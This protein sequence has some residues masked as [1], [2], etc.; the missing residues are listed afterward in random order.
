[1]IMECN[2]TRQAVGVNE[3]V[4]DSM[5]EVPLEADIMLPDYCPDIVKILKCSL[6][7]CVKSTHTQGRQL[8]LEGVCSVHILYLGEDGSGTSSGGELR[9]RSIDYK[10]PYTKKLDLK[11]E[12]DQALV[13]L[14]KD[15]CYCNCRAVSKRRMELRASLSYKICAVSCMQMQAVTDAVD[16]TENPMGI[17]LRKKTLEQNSFVTQS[18]DIM[19]VNEE[20]EL[21][22]GKPS[23]RN[24]ISSRVC[25]VMNDCK[26]ISGKIITKGQLNIQILYTPN[27]SENGRN[28]VEQMEY[29]L[30][31][32]GVIDAPGADDSC[33]CLAG[34]SVC[35]YELSPIAD[36]DGENTLFQLR[37]QVVM[38]AQV[39]RKTQVCLADDCYS[40]R[41]A[42]EGKTQ[43]ASFLSMLDAVEQRS[44]YKGEIELPDG[45]ENI[46]SGWGSVEGTSIRQEESDETQEKTMVVAVKLNL[47][48]LALDQEGA[49]QFYDKTEDM[50]IK[51]PL[52][53]LQEQM[54]LIF[55]PQVSVQSF[56]YNRN[57]EN[58]QVRCEVMVHGCLAG[59]K[60]CCVMGDIEVD[61]TKPVEREDDCSLTIYYA[62]AGENLWEIAKRY[63][64]AMQSVM[65]SN[66]QVELGE[67]GTIPKREMLLIP[68]LSH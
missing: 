15:S 18:R 60:R 29:S 17:Q 54:K 67:S 39:C 41:Y 21:A 66:S 4:F 25:A 12:A 52:H 23:V 30:P 35:E 19:E 37:A 43:A 7:S 27:Q 56:D 13:F 20:L 68:I 14:M 55:F 45:I 61:Q 32:S 2:A 8:C 28:N 9:M 46:I 38:S 44:M 63:H 65:E 36:Q 1:M 31:I 11:Q 58:L 49:V 3:T 6:D 62:D 16:D 51:I 59:L 40:T 22:S 10:I 48:L 42:C 24:L 47:C 57:G 33:N 5:A 26:L 50:E 34:Y 64:T 53:D